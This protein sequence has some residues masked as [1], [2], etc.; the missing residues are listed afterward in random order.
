MHLFLAALAVL[1]V[2]LGFGGFAFGGLPTIVF[3]VLAGFCLLGA[4]KLRSNR[5]RR[6]ES[7]NLGRGPH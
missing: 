1:F 4:W 7:G 6:R 5:Q 3:W 2:I